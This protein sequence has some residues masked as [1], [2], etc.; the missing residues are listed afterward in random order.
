MQIFAA[1]TVIFFFGVGLGAVA[2]FMDQRR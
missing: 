2:W 1:L